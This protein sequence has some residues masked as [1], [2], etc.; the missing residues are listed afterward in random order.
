MEL[1]GDFEPST[2]SESKN[3]NV[4]EIYDTYDNEEHNNNWEEESVV[5]MPPMID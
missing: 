5:A 4:G 1:T 2:R 3:S